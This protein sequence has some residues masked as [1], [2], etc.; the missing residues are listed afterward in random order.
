MQPLFLFYQ[1]KQQEPRTW[2]T[3]DDVIQWLA[4]EAVKDAERENHV[5]LDYR[6]DSIKTVDK[7]LGQVHETYV[8]D[9]SPSP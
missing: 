9:P 3:T 1:R 6:F 4:S 7:I 5:H 2:A 8:K